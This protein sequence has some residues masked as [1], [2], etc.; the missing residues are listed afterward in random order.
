MKYLIVTADPQHA[1]VL[2]EIAIAA[3]RHWNYPE[4]WIQFWIP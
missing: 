4:T 3:K 1:G 2:T